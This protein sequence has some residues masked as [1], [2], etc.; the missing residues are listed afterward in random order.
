MKITIRNIKYTKYTK[1]C[2]TL[3]MSESCTKSRSGLSSAVI[4]FAP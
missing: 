4:F 1:D 2:H 3:T